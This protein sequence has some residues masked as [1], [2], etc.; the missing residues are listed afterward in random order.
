MNQCAL[1]KPSDIIDK[2]KSIQHIDHTKPQA[3]TSEKVT[4]SYKLVINSQTVN[5]ILMLFQ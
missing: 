1:T 2:T 5:L 3:M 4:I